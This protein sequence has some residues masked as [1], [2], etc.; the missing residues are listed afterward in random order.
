[1]LRKRHQHVMHE[2]SNGPTCGVVFAVG[3]KI[4][5]DQFVYA[6]IFTAVLYTYLQAAHGDFASIPQALQVSVAPMQ[7]LPDLL[8]QSLH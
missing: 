6:P 4:A 8:L 7:M 5:I 3:K 2:C 1:M